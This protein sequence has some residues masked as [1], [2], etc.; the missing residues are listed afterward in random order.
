MR[1]KT[2]SA[3]VR[4]L[5]RHLNRNGWNVASVYDGEQDETVR[6]ETEALDLVF[7]LDLSRVYFQ[8]RATDARHSVVLVQG[9]G[10]DII[11]DWNYAEGDPDC[12]D[13]LMNEYIDTLN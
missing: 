12:F 1:D 13:K 2:E 11:S 4:G 8:C 9:N 7:N 6:T 5:I 10:S 3:I